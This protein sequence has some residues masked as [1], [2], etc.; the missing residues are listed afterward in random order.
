M[1]TIPP[2]PKHIYAA[3]AKAPTVLASDDLYLYGR[4]CIEAGL[5]VPSNGP[6][7]DWSR[8]S[9][10]HALLAGAMGRTNANDAL[11]AVERIRLG[12]ATDAD[13]GRAVT[14]AAFGG[15]EEIVRMLLESGAITDADRGLVVTWA[16]SRGDAETVRILLAS[17]TISDDH[18]GRAVRQAA[19][20][21]HEETVRRL[22][23]SGAIT[24]VD[25]GWAVWLAAFDG[26][27]AI[28]RLLRAA[29]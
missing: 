2:L 11:A 18:R 13:R 25:R 17:G 9:V 21:G 29:E 24:D 6:P 12:E 23:A 16:A 3:A 7:G 20:G 8:Q 26:D 22:L 27:A 10:E 28:V 1:T 5:P 15:H 14:W 4:A 19:Y